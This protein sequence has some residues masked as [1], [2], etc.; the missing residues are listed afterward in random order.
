MI[1]VRK[2]ASRMAML[3][4]EQQVN[5]ERVLDE[6]LA[7]GFSLEEISVLLKISVAEIESW[8]ASSAGSYVR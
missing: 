6:L 2:D 4:K 3:E 7:Q 1:S 5:R 8:L